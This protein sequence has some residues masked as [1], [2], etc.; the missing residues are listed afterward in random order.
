MKK[1]DVIFMIFDE[2]D[3]VYIDVET[4]I[5]FLRPDENTKLKDKLYRDALNSVADFLAD[6]HKEILEQKKQLSVVFNDGPNIEQ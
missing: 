4:L 1:D 6:K 5:N 3:K 2:D